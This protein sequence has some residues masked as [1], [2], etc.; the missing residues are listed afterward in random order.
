MKK[1]E[2]IAHISNLI[3]E[4]EEPIESFQLG[5]SVLLKSI[6]DVYL[7]IESFDVET[8]DVYTYL[9]D[10]ETSSS[11]VKYTDIDKKILKEIESTLVEYI[12]D[13]F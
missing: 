5:K 2:I 6:G 8:C 12:Q 13:N 9:G 1:K 3:K 11:T 4:N 10:V 7:Q